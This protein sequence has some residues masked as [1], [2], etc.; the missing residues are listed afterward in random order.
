MS[1]R[2]GISVLILALFFGY[3]LPA[4]STKKDPF[5]IIVDWNDKSQRLDYQRRFREF[6][7][8]WSEMSI[9]YS[10]KEGSIAEHEKCVQLIRDKDLMGYGLVF[11]DFLVKGYGEKNGD[12]REIVVDKIEILYD[13][14]GHYIILASYHSDLRKW[15][16]V[17][18]LFGY[19]PKTIRTVVRSRDL[20]EGYMLTDASYK[21][22]KFLIDLAKVCR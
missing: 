8:T 5:S 19:G 13:V 9:A 12:V 10:R 1:R 11:T 20:G 7:I 4:E 18:K 15:T 16:S 3:V 2:V 14:S 21:L 22:L 17:A 6:G